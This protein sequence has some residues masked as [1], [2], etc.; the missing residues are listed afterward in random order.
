[1]G[2]DAKR[3]DGWNAEAVAAAYDAWYETP[4][5]R[6]VDRLEK[7]AVLG[8]LGDRTDGV[9]VDLSCGTGS[10][11]LALAGRGFR[12]VGVD[13]SEP[14]LRVARAKSAQA[15]LD[16]SWLRADASA[17]PFR[18]GV[19]DL[20][21]MIL[22]LEFVAEPGRV[23]QEAHRVLEPGGWLVAAILNRSGLWTLWRRLERRFVRSIWRE[24]KFLGPE[25]LGALLREQGFS[26][27][28]WRRAVHFLPLLARGRTG[29]L[30]RWEAIG[31]RWMPGWAAF[32]AVAARRA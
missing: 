25:E 20:A 6:L 3:A 8:L 15:K 9:A 13:A 12:V 22:G 18:P 26:A 32:V 29:W 23:L 14:M 24:A 11:A 27:Q 4:L 30:G 21:T 10:Y 17:L 16:V 19:F 5:G 2:D 31:A 1:M 7:N 28:R